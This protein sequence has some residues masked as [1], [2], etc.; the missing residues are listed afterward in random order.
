M[1]MMAMLL[2]LLLLLC[3]VARRVHRPMYRVPRYAEIVEGIVLGWGAIT[4]GLCWWE[5]KIWGGAYCR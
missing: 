1:M 4:G 5:R 3:R 2:Q